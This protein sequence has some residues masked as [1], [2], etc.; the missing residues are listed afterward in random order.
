VKLLFGKHRFAEAAADAS[1]GAVAEGRSG[2]FAA[3]GDRSAYRLEL[4]VLAIAVLAVL[5]FS[6]FVDGFATVGNLVNLAKNSS[7]LAILACGMAAVIITRGLDL[8]QIA[9]MVAAATVFGLLVVQGYGPVGALAGAAALAV[10]L[11]LL[12]GWLVA[13]IEIPSLLTTLATA[14]L[15][16]GASRW[17]ILRGEYLVLLPKDLPLI[18]FLS[19]GQIAF[20]PAPVFICL[21]VLLAT[22]FFLTRTVIGRTLFAMGDNAGA[23]RLTG[24]P[25]RTAT[26]AVYVFSGI[27]A[28]V[29]GVIVASASGTVDFRVVTNGTLLF[30]VIMV[31]VLGGISL[32]GG[33]GGLFNIFAGVL[34]VSVLRNGMTLMDLSTQVQGL[35]KGLTLLAAIVTDNLLNL[36]D[37]ETDTQGDL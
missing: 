10:L 29:A 33:R 1:G 20:L 23:A 25:V 18:S 17:G 12:N 31:V 36:R 30:E 24:L 11:G 26:L 34:L 5:G 28:V 19:T 4:I 27:T 22:F 3:L 32:R 7:S 16:T 21:I 8:S 6:M 35:V 2:R 13:Y 9:V 15:I 14:L 37:P